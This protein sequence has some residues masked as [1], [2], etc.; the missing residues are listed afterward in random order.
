MR[1][2]PFC[3][4]DV[5]RVHDSYSPDNVHAPVGGPVMSSPSSVKTKPYVLKVFA[6]PDFDV[7]ALT[8]TYFAHVFDETELGFCAGGRIHTIRLD[9]G[10]LYVDDLPVLRPHLHH[11]AISWHQRT[12]GRFT[13]GHLAFSRGGTEL[14]GVVYQGTSASTA[15]ELHVLA[16]TIVSSTYHTEISTTRVPAGATSVEW[17]EGPLLEI[18]YEQGLTDLV[19]KPVVVLDGTDMS[20]FA[21]WGIDQKTQETTLEINAPQVTCSWVPDCYLQATIAFD[22]SQPVPTFTGTVPSRCTDTAGSGSYR[23]KGVADG[24]RSNPVTAP[25][26][27]KTITEADIE[28]DPTLSI[29]ELMSIVPDDSVAKMAD[30][31]LMSN[32]KWAMSRDSTEKVWL[33]QYLGQQPPTLTPQRQELVTR[34]LDWYQK[35]FVKS[36]LGYTFDHYDGA[37]CATVHLDDDVQRPKLKSYLETGLAK[38]T[39]FNIQQ[40]GIYLQAFVAAKPRINAYLDDGGEKWAKSLFDVITST[41]QL[42]LMINRIYGAA[43]QNGAMTP[44]NNLATL[45]SVLQQGSKGTLAQSYMEKLMAAVLNNATD[46]T[47]W[48]SS[49]QAMQWLPEFLQLF[50]NKVAEDP[51]Q[52]TDAKA[53]ADEM[54]AMVNAAMGGSFT[55]LAAELADL[56]VNATGG[57]ILEKTQS[58]QAAFVQKWPKFAKVGGMLFIASWGIGIGMVVNAFQNWKDLKPADKA[59][60][61]LTTVQLALDATKVVP[62]VLRG[63]KEMGLEGW[64]AFTQW[65]HGLAVQEQLIELNELGGETEWLRNGATETTALFE[66]G[67]RTVQTEGTLWSKIMKAAP[68]IVGIV[69]IAISAVFTV[70]SIVDF[71]TDIVNGKPITDIMF[72]GVMMLANIGMTVCLVMEL[73]FASVVFAIAGAVFAIIGVIFAL[74]AAFLPKPEPESPLNDFMRTVVIPFV[75]GLPQQTPPPKPGG[76]PLVVRYA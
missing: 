2:P 27:A 39:N 76:V 62:M 70:W 8:Q 57:N 33:K 55:K 63:I 13:S 19:P 60:A 29:A 4:V 1:Q 46:Q 72:D 38:D 37:G 59:K 26:Q 42:I 75:D 67:T 48:A 65:R 44:A 7:S 52:Y 40:N 14:H 16:T 45:L 30:E 21:S 41:P 74:V 68:K 31:M 54:V 43:G 66:A 36:H 35:C 11:H 23:W 5:R 58:A 25:A 32:M 20:S 28:T 51:G 18:G 56:V 10:T 64:R 24:V 6:E 12:A 73:A 3:D 15:V 71:I 50:V 53:V 22:A 69:G 61:I 17:T 49:S 47:A 9:R 34:S